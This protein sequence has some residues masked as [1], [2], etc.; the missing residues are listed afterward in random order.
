MKIAEIL[1]QSDKNEIESYLA[2]QGY[3]SDEYVIRP[4][5]KVDFK[6][7]CYLVTNA[8]LLKIG[9][10]SDNGGSRPGNYENELKIDVANLGD[11]IPESCASFKLVS[12][13]LG[14]LDG[15]V[16]PKE[17]IQYMFNLPKLEDLH[18]IDKK[19]R[20]AERIE[21]EGKNV[22]KNILGL[23]R[24]KNLQNIY[25]NGT[26]YNPRRAN[27]FLSRLEKHKGHFVD[28]ATGELYDPSEVAMMVIGKH[29]GEGPRGVIAAQ[30][31]LDEMGLDDFSDL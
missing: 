2:D 24:I 8:T 25:Y 13:T 27:D 22:K 3:D 4:D 16:E 15:F 28:G 6:R 1:D 7:D 18:G 12:N 5:G 31:E 29:I 9:K 14:I 17:C 20:S 19:I 11:L 30:R 21:F 23:L 26:T 10:V